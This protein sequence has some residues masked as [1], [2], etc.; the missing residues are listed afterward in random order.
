M[1]PLLWWTC[2]KVYII[3]HYFGREEGR[4]SLLTAFIPLIVM[5]IFSP[6]DEELPPD[7]FPIVSTS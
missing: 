4:K 5:P 3:M 6:T 1:T 7:F 2:Q